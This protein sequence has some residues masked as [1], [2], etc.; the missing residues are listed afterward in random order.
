[1][2]K[3]D[4]EAFA[5][6]VLGA[7][8]LKKNSIL[9]KKIPKINILKKTK[10][11]QPDKIKI[12]PKENNFYIEKKRSEFELQ[13]SSIN[14]KLKK[15]KVPID[16]KV[17]F[18]GLSI[19]DAEDLFLRTVQ[20][21]YNKNSRCILFITGKGIINKDRFETESPKLYYGKIRNN[22]M[23]WVGSKEVKKYI[24]TVEQANIE[25]GADGAFFVYLRKKQ[26]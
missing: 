16:K 11:I 14:K 22:F 19:L 24:L 21:C 9:K 3:K 20:D 8:P 5:R 17:D 4:E 2:K 15:G 12:Y 6:S 23:S 18:H 25:H 1:M 10:N 7:K 26:T 13:T